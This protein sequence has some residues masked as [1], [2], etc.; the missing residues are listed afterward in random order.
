MSCSSNLEVNVVNNVVTAKN[1]TFDEIINHGLNEFIIKGLPYME[2]DKKY[3]VS[4]W[5]SN[6]YIEYKGDNIIFVSDHYGE[7]L[8]TGKEYIIFCP[9]Y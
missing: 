2:L 4:S 1:V 3:I 5:N 6:T 7:E 9:R 8:Q